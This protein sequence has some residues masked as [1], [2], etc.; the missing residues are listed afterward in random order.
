MKEAPYQTS[1]KAA[2]AEEATKTYLDNFSSKLVK[3]VGKNSAI[4]IQEKMKKLEEK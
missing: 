4:A 1:E 2:R 3:R